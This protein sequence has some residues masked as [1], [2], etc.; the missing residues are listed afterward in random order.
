MHSKR[1]NTPMQW[2]SP[3]LT[4]VALSSLQPTSGCGDAKGTLP[5]LMLHQNL[6]FRSA[7]SIKVLPFTDKCMCA[8][9]QECR[10]EQ[11]LLAD[12]TDRGANLVLLCP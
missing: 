9:V 3:Q 12:P 7:F 8:L 5:G 11:P 2:L 6:S 1:S 4:Q 10:T